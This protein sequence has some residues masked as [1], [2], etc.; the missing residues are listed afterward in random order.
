MSHTTVNAS[1]DSRGQIYIDTADTRVIVDVADIPNGLTLREQDSIIYDPTDPNLG[2]NPERLYKFYFSVV[3]DGLPPSRMYGVFSADGITWGTPFALG[4]TGEDPSITTYWDAPTTAYR[5]GSGLLT[6]Y[7]EGGAIDM[8]TSTD[9]ITWSSAV[10]AIPQ[11]GTGLWDDNLVG[12]PIARYISSTGT[13]WVGYEGINLTVFG[14]EYEE[15]FGYVYGPARD[16]LT[17]SPNNPV[18]TPSAEPVMTTQSIVVDAVYP[19]SDGTKIYLIGHSGGDFGDTVFRGETTN[20]DPTTWELGDIIWSGTEGMGGYRNDLTLDATSNAR[21]VSAPTDDLT[22]VSYG[23]TG[24]GAYYGSPQINLKSSGVFA[25]KTR[26]TKIGGVF[27]PS[28]AAAVADDSPLYWWRMS[29]GSGASTLA[30]EISAV[31]ATV[32]GATTGTTGAVG[33]GVS[34]DGSNDYTSHTTLGSFGGSSLPSSSVEFWIKTTTTAQTTVLG[35]VNTGTD[36]FMEIRL[37]T[38]AADSL[39]VGRHRVDIRGKSG[40]GRLQREVTFDIFDGNWH[41]VVWTFNLPTSG[42]PSAACYIDGVS[43]SVGGP[44]VTTFSAGTD[45][46]GF[47]WTVGARNLRGVIDRFAAIELDELALY[48]TQLSG[49][50]VLAHYEAR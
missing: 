16:N 21:L 40:T 24:R 42:S 29:E 14:P 48:G 33:S 44:G 32:A 34:Y 8:R 47:P 5:D 26:R 3:E 45:N 9:G 39:A 2:T 13:W 20:L 41:H 4:F 36:F 17:R 12:S 37:N 25:T 19:N 15:A 38:N 23:L 49:A 11:A 27:R 46:F 6:M 1:R 31:S 22:M 43:R 28:Y 10:I 7:F 18:W 35:T 30:D 50:R